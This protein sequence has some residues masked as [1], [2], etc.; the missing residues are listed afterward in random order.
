MSR[1]KL[2]AYTL[3]LLD[4]MSEEFI[5]NNGVR[6]NYEIRKSKTT[7]NGLDVVW[8]YGI[9]SARQIEREVT[10]TSKQD[11]SK[12]KIKLHNHYRAS[13]IFSRQSIWNKSV[14]QAQKEHKKQQKS[15]V[16]RR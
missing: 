16:K 3:K 2:Y 5:H 10:I 1:K 14:H 12:L 9:E 11:I 15:W 6:F 8:G 7:T 4:E 13:N